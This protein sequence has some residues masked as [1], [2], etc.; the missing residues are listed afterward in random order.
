MDD[1]APTGPIL[2]L[3]RLARIVHRRSD[4]DLLGIRLKDLWTLAYLRERGPVTQQTVMDGLCI[5]A[6]YCVLLLNELE[7]A[8]LVVRRRDPADR[9]RHIVEITAA[10]QLAL[11]HA[12]HAQETIEDDV[13]GGLD[14]A[15][16]ETLARLL[17]RA[18]DSTTPL[19]AIG[20]PAA[21]RS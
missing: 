18:L 12:E 6:N 17:K 4:P 15:E 1:V 16:R 20:A 10:G 14:A 8:G 19:A 3:T 5:D 11:E 2:L 13:L 9:R 21:Q 7:G